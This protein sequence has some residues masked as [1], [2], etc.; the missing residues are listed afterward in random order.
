[1]DVDYDDEISGVLGADRLPRPAWL[2]EFR[3]DR[4]GWMIHD[5]G[6]TVMFANPEAAADWLGFVLTT[7]SR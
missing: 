1:M 3:P 2:D 6:R 7:G 5:D 4:H